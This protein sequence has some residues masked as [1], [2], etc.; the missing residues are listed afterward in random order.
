MQKWFY[1]IF[2]IDHELNIAYMNHRIWDPLVQENVGRI[3]ET[4]M[5]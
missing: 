1:F 4:I 5:N 2:Y 3:D